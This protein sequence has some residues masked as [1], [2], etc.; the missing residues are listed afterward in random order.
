MTW[1]RVHGGGSG[2]D[3]SEEVAVQTPLIQQIREAIVGKATEANATAEH[4]EVGYSAYVGQVLIDG[5]LEPL[6]G[7]DFGE[8]TV[9]KSN[10]IVIEHSLGVMPSQIYL[11]RTKYKDRDATIGE[12]LLDTQMGLI[13]QHK[14][15][16][17]YASTS[18][19]YIYELEDSKVVKSDSDVTFNVPNRMRPYAGTYKWV[20]IA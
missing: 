4:I 20:F 1:F 17:T 9:S 18:G 16:Y 15:Y 12:F 11:L 14:G 7:I 5:T 8:V 10:S 13:E 6:T 19:I 3:V 2:E